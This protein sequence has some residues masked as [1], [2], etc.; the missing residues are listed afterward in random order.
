[1]EDLRVRA[2]RAFV[3]VTLALLAARS[4]GATSFT[5]TNLVSDIPGLAALTDPDLKNPWGVS[6]SATSPL[7]TSNQ[8]TSTANLF[9]I[10]GLTV[11]QNALE[12]TIPKTAAGTQGPTG[13]VNNNTSAFLV[14][15]TPASFIFASLNG[16]I[17]AW[18]QSAGTTAQIKATTP[19][20]T[21]TGLA[22]ANTASGPFLYAA[23]G[24][25]NRIDVFD[26]SFTNVTS[27]SFAGKFV[28][29]NIPAG[30][31]PFN[32]ENIGGKIYITYAPAG[33]P[34]QTSAIEGQG[35]VSVFDTSGNFAQQLIS[36][37]KLA[38][39]W[40]MTLAPASFDGF[41]GDLLVGNF[42]Y[43]VGEINAFD[44]TTGSF[45][46]TLLSNP[47]FQGLWA[48]TFGNGGNGGDPNILYF[49][50]G[51]NAETDGLLAAVTAVA[52]PNTGFLVAVGVVLIATLRRRNFKILQLTGE[53]HRN[54]KTA[55]RADSLA[56][57]ASV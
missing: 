49:T 47:N 51:L 16:T 6:F 7:W 35:F 26:G 44:P 57:T 38:S 28:D 48:L 50:T 29:P 56:R 31:V 42:S 32:V 13:Q 54:R 17:S 15:G 11:T 22:I 45:L 27:T 8:G 12:V 52:E 5:Q 40:G 2:I 23:N 20:A 46:G 18:N 10:K 1:M 53:I 41:A 37:S 3:V 55:G 30:F 25:Q 36:G 34:A 21:Y 43:A 24:G 19:G 39:P 9:N 4:A 14:N 33:R